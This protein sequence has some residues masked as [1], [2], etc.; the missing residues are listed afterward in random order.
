MKP[1]GISTTPL[2]HFACQLVQDWLPTFVDAELCDIAHQE[3]FAD[4]RDHL[5]TCTACAADHA[6]LLET[7]LWRENLPW[8]NRPF[9]DH[10]CSLGR[11]IV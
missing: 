10:P 9:V 3:R 2:T 4:L 1:I 5:A 8:S 7:M 11:N 6:D